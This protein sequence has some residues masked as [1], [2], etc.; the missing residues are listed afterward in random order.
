MK[1]F[2]PAGLEASRPLVEALR[3]EA[4]KYGRTL[5]QVALNWVINAHGDM[6]VAIPGAIS[7]A[8][9]RENAGALSFKLSEEDL[10]FLSRAAAG[11]KL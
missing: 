7:A 6:V 4:E 3:G 2:K 11:V 8:Q 10:D 1:A 5:G 9:A